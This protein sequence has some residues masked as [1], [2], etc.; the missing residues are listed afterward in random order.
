MKRVA[1]INRLGALLKQNRLGALLKQR[2]TE[3][4]ESW[5]E[6]GLIPRGYW[7]EFKTVSK[8]PSTKDKE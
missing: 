7:D 6:A 2:R 5:Q 4:I 3:L 1:E 8:P